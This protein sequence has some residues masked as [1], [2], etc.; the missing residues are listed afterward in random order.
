M[1]HPRDPEE[2]QALA[3]AYGV[4]PEYLHPDGPPSDAE[5]EAEADRLATIYGVNPKYWP[6]RGRPEP[7]D[8]PPDDPAA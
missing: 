2:V 6:R 4:R 7:T 5:E 1:T 8:D 3:D